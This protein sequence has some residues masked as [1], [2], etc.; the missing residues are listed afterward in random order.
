MRKSGHV[1]TTLLNEPMPNP[2]VPLTEFRPVWVVLDT[3]VVL[4][5]LVFDD[6]QAAPLRAALEC[7]RLRA[8]TNDATLFELVD[9][10]RRPFLTPWDV[11]VDQ[12]LASLG[13]WSQPVGDAPVQPSPPA[14][15]CSDGDD[16]KFID[17]ALATGARWLISHDRAL[18]ALAKRARLRGLDILTPRTWASC[19]G[20]ARPAATQNLSLK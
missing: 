8:V 11:S 3:N 14:P 16:Q 5:L 1:A 2:T 9:V 7:G 13:S 10:L 18:L 19:H 20:D 4:D 17:L 15:R 6:A 12:V